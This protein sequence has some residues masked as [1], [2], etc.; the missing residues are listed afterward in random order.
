[1]PAKYHKM[2]SQTT[3]GWLLFTF[4]TSASSLRDNKHGVKYQESA[5][6]LK[7]KI[8]LL[9]ELFLPVHAKALC[10]VND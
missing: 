2:S 3:V 6:Q 1:M 9:R 4:I 5:S 8:L 7:D 10:Q